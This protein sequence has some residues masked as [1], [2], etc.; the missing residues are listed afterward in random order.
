MNNKKLKI[1]EKALCRKY[2]TNVKKLIQA[3][4]RGLSDSDITGTLGIDPITL[5]QIR[6]EIKLVHRRMRLTEKNN[7][8]IC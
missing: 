8:K 6:E 3:W 1:D 4:K 2:R 5:Y 7:F